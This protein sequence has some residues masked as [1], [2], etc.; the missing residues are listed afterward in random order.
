M[1]KLMIPKIIKNKPARKSKL[2]LILQAMN[3]PNLIAIK[4]I[5][6]VMIPKIIAGRIILFTSNARDTPIRRL[7]ILTEIVKRI[8]PKI[9]NT[10]LL[11][12]FLS[13]KQNNP[14]ATKISEL[15][16]SPIGVKTEID[17]KK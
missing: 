9:F 14:R 5:V 16:I 7:S 12:S 2:Y 1:M 11:F 4:L 17:L 13:K 15:M 10:D 8:K 3:D 6:A